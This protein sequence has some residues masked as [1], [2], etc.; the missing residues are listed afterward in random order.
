MGIDSATD[1]TDKCSVDAQRAAL[2]LIRLE[3][4]VQWIDARDLSDNA[5]LML[6]LLLGFGALG[7]AAHDGM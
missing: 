6:S 2:E 3:R 1:L 5:A 7:R 4:Q